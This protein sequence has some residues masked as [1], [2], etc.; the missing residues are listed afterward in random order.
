MKM[1][2]IKPPTPEDEAALEAFLSLPSNPDGTLSLGEVRG[3]LFAVAAAPDLVKPKEWLQF[4]FVDNEPEFATME[5]AQQIMGTMMALYNEANDVVRTEGDRRQRGCEFREDLLSNLE[6]DAEVSQWSRGFTAG[7]IWLDESWDPYLSGEME[8]EMG[9]ITMT[10]SFFGSR[11]MAE[12]FLRESTK[13]GGTLDELAA[14]MHRL[15]PDAVTVYA[16]MGMAIRRAMEK[17]ERRRS[18]ATAA[19]PGVG[20]NQPCPCGSGKKYK[21]CCGV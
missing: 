13:P 4:I 6:P 1:P 16:R 3:F 14:T 18:E 7:H 20:R 8:D 9:A 21:R 19:T 15:F 11:S 17:V 5:E 10:L 2:P 12:G